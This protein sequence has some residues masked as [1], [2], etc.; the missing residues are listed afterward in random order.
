MQRLNGPSDYRFRHIGQMEVKETGSQN[1]TA[2]CVST[3]GRA[4]RSSIFFLHFSAETTA[5]YIFFPLKIGD[6]HYALALWHNVAGGRFKAPGRR[7]KGRR[8]E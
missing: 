8:K 2:T 5:I 1:Q 3:T 7:T 4:E 6:M